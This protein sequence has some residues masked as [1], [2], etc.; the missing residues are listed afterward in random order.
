MPIDTEIVESGCQV[1]PKSI[2]PY[3]GDHDNNHHQDHPAV[4]SGIQIRP[5][6]PVKRPRDV[7]RG[8]KVDPGSNC[9]LTD[10]I[11]PGGNPGPTMIAQSEGPK[12]QPSR[13]WV[14]RSEFCH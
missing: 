12:I 2:D 14:S 4:I 6:N 1:D 10:H 7:N 3:L 13:R 8:G 11:E 9:N 5:D